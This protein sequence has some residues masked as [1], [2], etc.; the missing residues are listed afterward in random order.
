VPLLWTVL[1]KAGTSDTAE[2]TALMRRYR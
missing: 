2:R 1:D